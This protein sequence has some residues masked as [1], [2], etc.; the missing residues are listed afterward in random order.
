LRY[1][2]VGGRHRDN[3]AQPRNWTERLAAFTPATD[4]SILK[5]FTSASARHW[6]VKIVTAA[7]AA[8]I[9]VCMVGV[10][11]TFP[12]P[13]DGPYVPAD[14]G[15]EADVT[16]SKTGQFLGATFRFSPYVI[17][18][19]WSNDAILRTFLDATIAPW[20]ALYARY[21]LPFF[22][23]WDLTTYTA[24]VR[25]VRLTLGYRYKPSFR[26][27]ATVDSFELEMEG[28]KE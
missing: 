12:Y 26:V 17:K 15:I 8:Q 7:V 27:L 2:E 14:E 25:Y 22:W 1:C 6:R 19:V 11:M 23:A 5:T 28:V 10:R 16:D 20:W 9:A 24:D 13:P 4:N 3:E 18:P 21:L